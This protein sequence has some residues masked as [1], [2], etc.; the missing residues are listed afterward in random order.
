MANTIRLCMNEVWTSVCSQFELGQVNSIL[1]CVILI[2]DSYVCVKGGFS[3]YKNVR[4]PSGVSG[5]YISFQSGLKPVLIVCSFKTTK[6]GIRSKLPLNGRPHDNY[7]KSNNC[8]LFIYDTL[9]HMY[10]N[11]QTIVTSCTYMGQLN[12]IFLF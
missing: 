8:I 10:M 11:L 2:V 1:Y 3:F 12:N 4:L 7:H 9:L 6:L 5:N